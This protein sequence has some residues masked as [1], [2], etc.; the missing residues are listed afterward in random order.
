MKGLINLLLDTRLI[1]C[2]N[3]RCVSLIAKK[4]W[5]CFVFICFTLIMF[6]FFFLYHHFQREE[7]VQFGKSYGVCHYV[8]LKIILQ[9][10][11]Q[12]NKKPQHSTGHWNCPLQHSSQ[13]YK[14]SFTPW[15]WKVSTLKKLNFSLKDKGC[16]GSY[17][18]GPS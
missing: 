17:N 14:L 9:T 2:S 4:T 16:H 12:T 5:F 7:K 13:W 18:R 8:C 15:N 3:D 6:F 10:S 1:L 11:K